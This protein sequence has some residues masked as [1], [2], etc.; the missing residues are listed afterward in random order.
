MKCGVAHGSSEGLGPWGDSSLEPRSQCSFFHHFSG[1][2][3]EQWRPKVPA[4]A[5]GY[6]PTYGR[7]WFPVILLRGPSGT[8]VVTERNSRNQKEENRRLEKRPEE[9]K[10]KVWRM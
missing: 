2:R 7:G 10:D 6:T 4:R 1:G 3:R 5:G 9:A 8:D